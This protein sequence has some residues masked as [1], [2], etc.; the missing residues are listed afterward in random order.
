MDDIEKEK[1]KLLHEAMRSVMFGEVGSKGSGI[2]INE[3]TNEERIKFSIPI[4]DDIQRIDKAFKNNGY[5]LYLVGGSIRDAYIGGTPKD[6]DLVTDAKPDEIADVLKDKNFVENILRTGESFAVINVITVNGNE[7][8]M[9]TFREES[10]SKEDRRRPEAVEYSDIYGDVKR[11]DLTINALYYDIDKGEIIDLVGGVE[12]ID[13]STVETVGDAEERFEEDRLRKLRV[14]R[15]AARYGSE[16]DE[17]VDDV[18]RK[19]NTL[20]GV[21]EERI[22]E[23]FIKGIE[24]AKSIPYF[25]DLLDEYDFFDQIFNG[26]NVDRSSFVEERDHI[27]LIGTLLSENNPAEVLSELKDLKYNNKEANAVAFLIKLLDLNEENA[28]EL[29]K[30][31]NKVGV[32]DEQIERF[33]EHNNIDKKLISAFNE[34]ELS[35]TGD[36]AMEKYGI[37]QKGPEVGKAIKK[38]E[39]ERF[40][41]LL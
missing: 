38:M 5:E 27:V 16:I 1:R 6:Y 4:P 19:N 21:S 7:Y 33:A 35:V 29:K 10:Y 36:E 15:F 40:R 12:D 8:E 20:E 13:N 11:R 2:R 22:R 25:L 23:E 9:A 37:E 3:N 32:T 14:I 31:Q 17:E 41:E 30:L 28:Y 18:L 24:K 34:F 26:L 39:T